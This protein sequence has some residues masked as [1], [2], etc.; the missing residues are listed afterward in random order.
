[1]E[2]VLKIGS[3][4]FIGKDVLLKQKVQGIARRISCFISESRRSPRAG[5]KIFDEAGQVIGEVTSGTFA[6]ALQLGVGLGFIEA[7]NRSVGKKIFFGD[8]KS[9]AAAEI[10]KRPFYKNGSLKH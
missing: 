1:M 8:E 9:K 10:V 5:H 2:R 6:P 3:K 7:S 4:D